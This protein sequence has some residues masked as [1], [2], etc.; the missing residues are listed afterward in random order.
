ME[1]AL[2]LFLITLTGQYMPGM[3]VLRNDGFKTNANPVVAR[4]GLGSPLMA[5]FGSHAFNIAAI[6]A[7][8]ATG[9]EAHVALLASALACA[10]GK[11]ANGQTATAT[12]T[13]CKGAASKARRGVRSNTALTVVRGKPQSQCGSLWWLYLPVR[14]EVQ[15]LIHQCTVRCGDR[16]GPVGRRRLIPFFGDR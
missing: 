13:A 7:A 5:P 2:P 4:P 16:G 9:R 6:T 12:A 1:L 11:R 8:I 3:L 15:W 14:G 10:P